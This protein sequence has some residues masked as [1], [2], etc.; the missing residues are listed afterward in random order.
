MAISFKYKSVKRHDGNEIK[1]PSIPVNLRGKSPNW[2]E[3]MALVDS[4]ADLSVVPQDVA[5]LLNFDLSGEKDKSRG[6][7]GEVEVINTKMQVNINRKHEDY[8]FEVPV[9]VVLGDSKIPV[10]LGRE[11]FFDQFK[12]T[13]E[14]SSEMV[15]LKKVNPNELK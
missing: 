10:L 1:T 9:Q 13:F 3:F 15:I 8:T 4:G 5:E 6:I 2:I 14:Q 11:G 7:G 12:I